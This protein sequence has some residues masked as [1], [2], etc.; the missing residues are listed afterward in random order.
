LSQTD[1]PLF[2]RMQEIDPRDFSAARLWILMD[3]G[4]F[5]KPKAD[6]FRRFVKNFRLTFVRIDRIMLLT[7]K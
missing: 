1:A 3:F 7:P 2:R 5:P 4:I 6:F